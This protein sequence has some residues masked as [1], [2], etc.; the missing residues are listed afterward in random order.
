MSAMFHPI[1]PILAAVLIVAA[2][3]IVAAWRNRGQQTPATAPCTWT[4]DQR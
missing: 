2:W 1:W 3:V 4:G